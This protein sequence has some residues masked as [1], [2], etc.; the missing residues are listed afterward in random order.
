M[1][2]EPRSEW[3]GDGEWLH[4]SVEAC[5]LEES[6]KSPGN[7]W[8]FFRLAMVG[9]LS[10]AV[11]TDQKYVV[12]C[13]TGWQN[14]CTFMPAAH[15]TQLRSHIVPVHSSHGQWQWWTFPS[16]LGENPRLLNII[17]LCFF[18]TYTIFFLN[19]GMF[20]VFSLESNMKCLIYHIIM[21]NTWLFLNL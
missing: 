21:L 3:V 8:L 4:W 1:C 12:D 16:S 14:V 19:F 2:L 5:G 10:Y 20:Y 17:F 15:C 7:V 11:E 6:E 13:W 18:L 9:R